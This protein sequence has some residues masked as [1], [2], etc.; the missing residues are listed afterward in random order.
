MSHLATPADG[1]DT[2]G[3]VKPSAHGQVP[4]AVSVPGY[5]YSPDKLSADAAAELG[6]FDIDFNAENSLG[7][8]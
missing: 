5:P 8:S 2:H 3:F 7:T 1:Q 4:V 6:G